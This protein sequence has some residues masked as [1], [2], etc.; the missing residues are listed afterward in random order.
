MMPVALVW[1]V[2]CASAPEKKVENVE[3]REVSGIH[4]I[5]NQN[6]DSVMRQNFAMALDLLHA[7]DYTRAIELLEKMKENSQNHSAPYVNLAK[8]YI[9]VGNYEEAENNLKQAMHINPEHP[10]T[11]HELA[12]V[13]RKTGRY[14]ESR[15]LYEAVVSKY[16]EFM[17]A[18][19]NLGILCELYLDD[20]PCALAQYQ[21]YISDNP[22]EED[23]KLWIAGLKRR[24]GQ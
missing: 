7:G 11:L 12:L 23:V 15:S 10:V 5:E 18:R 3:N 20:A 24:M 17:P 16:P 19:K 22:D 13:Y 8:A 4:V 6:V 14:E 21:S 9:I 1:V 2:G